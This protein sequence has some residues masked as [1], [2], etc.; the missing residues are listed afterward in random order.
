MSS[1][2]AQERETGARQ[3]L[4]DVERQIKSAIENHRETMEPLS[5][6]VGQNLWGRQ[7]AKSIESVARG[8]RRGRSKK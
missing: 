1:Q 6:D 4:Q 2:D 8:V 3:E 7:L 5:V